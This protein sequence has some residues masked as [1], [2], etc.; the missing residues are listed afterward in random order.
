MTRLDF[1]RSRLGLSLG[2]GV[3]ALV[4]GLGAGQLSAS[5]CSNERIVL[6]DQCPSPS[7]PRATVAVAMDAGMQHVFAPIYG[8]SCAPCEG[9]EPEL[10]ADG[11]P[12]FVT[13]QSCGGDICIGMS[14]ITRV[15]PDLDSDGGEPDA[16]D[17]LMA[18][19][20]AGAEP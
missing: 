20:D 19:E 3:L 13:F 4:A 15:T 10:D 5:G 6:G 11:C 14:R 2:C 17:D 18:M 8:T 12:T 9:R 7:S 16:G 1:P